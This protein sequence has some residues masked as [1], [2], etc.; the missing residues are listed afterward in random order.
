V[1]GRPKRRLQMQQRPWLANARRKRRQVEASAAVKPASKMDACVPPIKSSAE[2]IRRILH[3]T[4]SQWRR[5]IQ[6][7][8]D[9]KDA[10]LITTYSTPLEAL[11]QSLNVVAEGDQPAV[12]YAHSV[13]MLILLFFQ[14]CCR[15]RLERTSR[16]DLD[17]GEQRPLTPR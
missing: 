11:G 6:F 8:G 13:M 10:I 14:Y 2:P 1:D 12:E 3:S 16:Q 5:L 7:R 15:P 4:P 17:R 9:R